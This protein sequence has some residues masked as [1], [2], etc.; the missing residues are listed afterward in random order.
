MAISLGKWIQIIYE[1]GQKKKR[2]KRKEEEM[3][4]KGTKKFPICS[5]KKKTK[6][7][8]R[9]KRPSNLT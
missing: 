4:R 3:K 1:K 9:K 6:G 5:P 2:R 8:E 7:E